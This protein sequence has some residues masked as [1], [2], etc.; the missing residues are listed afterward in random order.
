MLTTTAAGRTFDYGYCIGMVA[1]SGNG[2]TFPVD[3]A[4]TANGVV[5]V[6][7][8]AAEGLNQRVTSAPPSGGAREEQGRR[9]RTDA[10]APFQ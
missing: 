10:H 9:N 4:M 5:Y 3:F 8:R 2:F 6:I 7:N 1:M